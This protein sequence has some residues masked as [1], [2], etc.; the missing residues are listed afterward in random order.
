M[1]GTV[2]Q[3]DD[4]RVD[5]SIKACV[6][7]MPFLDPRRELWWRQFQ[8]GPRFRDATATAASPVPDIGLCVC[9]CVCGAVPDIALLI[10]VAAHSLVV[11]FRKPSWV[12]R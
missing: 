3:H 1:P 12:A 5:S 6:Q 4:R 8:F 7:S 9:V 11:R 2:G 10:Q